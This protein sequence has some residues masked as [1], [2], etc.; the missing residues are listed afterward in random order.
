MKTGNS[1]RTFSGFLLILIAVVFIIY[2]VVVSWVLRDGL[3]PDAIDSHSL[4]AVQRFL[5]GLAPMLLIASPI[6]AIGLWL[7]SP[8][9]W[10]NSRKRVPGK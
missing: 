3:G 2:S 6:G 7:I 1:Y 5:S 10:Q 9:L 8:I 4:I